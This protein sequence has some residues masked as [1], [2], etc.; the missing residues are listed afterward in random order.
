MNIWWTYEY[1]YCSTHIYFSFV[2]SVAAGMALLDLHTDPRD[3]E[4]AWDAVAPFAN[5]AAYDAALQQNWQQKCLVR[6]TQTESIRFLVCTFSWNN[7]S[8]RKAISHASQN[9]RRACS[10]RRFVKV[11]TAARDRGVATRSGSF[12]SIASAGPSR[13]ASFPDNR[14]SHLNT[15]S[16][17]IVSLALNTLT[18]R[19]EYVCETLLYSLAAGR[20]KQHIFGHRASRVPPF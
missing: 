2:S 5:Q 15:R 6:P 8:F 1:H 4:H 17:L 11:E 9:C 20:K 3:P 18:K 12:I 14:R 10:R 13:R 7:F 19:Q 16:L